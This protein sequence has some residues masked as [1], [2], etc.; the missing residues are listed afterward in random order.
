MK[1]HIL[2]FLCIV[3][4]TILSA[5]NTLQG[6]VFYRVSLKAYN[7]QYVD[8]IFKKEKT[9]KFAEQYLIK[10]FKNTKDVTSVLRFSKNESLYEVESKLK[11]EANKNL[12]MTAII[13]GGNTIYYTNSTEKDYYMQLNSEEPLRVDILPIKWTITQE[14]KKIGDYL[15]FKAVAVKKVR[16]DKPLI[17]I[18]AWFTPTI[19]VSFGPI[20]YFGLP[21]LVLEVSY[22]RINIKAV[23]IVLNPKE[24][25]VIKKPTKGKRIT[26]T[27]YEEMSKNFFKR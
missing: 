23:K 21:G 17:K 10:M 4:T 13:A 24:K 2:L 22:N 12:N 18:A 6:K 20:D 7:E 14:R 27:A 25:I 26:N 11:N 8:S 15:C 19:P 5:Q 16:D 3:F 9:T 1:K